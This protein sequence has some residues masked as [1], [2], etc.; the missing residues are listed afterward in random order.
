MNS[1]FQDETI[2]IWKKIK[3]KF[4]T[5]KIKSNRLDWGAVYSIVQMIGNVQYNLLNNKSPVKSIMSVLDVLSNPEYYNKFPD[6]NCDE[7]LGYK[8]LAI[9][10][11]QG[12][13]ILNVIE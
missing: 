1:L 13:K 9:K 10:L 2:S 8:L 6:P 12:L 7:A 11:M 4:F 3:I 5:R